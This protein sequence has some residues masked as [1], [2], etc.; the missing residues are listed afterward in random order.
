M[1][2][3]VLYHVNGTMPTKRIE[4]SK[5]G[6]I[7]LIDRVLDRMDLDKLTA[8]LADKLGEKL[9]ESLNVDGLVMTLF[10][11]HGAELQQGLVAA[12][13]ERL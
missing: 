3:K 2:A 1:V 5:P 7:K 12:I 10:E 4:N 11:N 8:S 13:A 6:A 9:L